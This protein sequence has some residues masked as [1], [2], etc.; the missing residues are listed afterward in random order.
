MVISDEYLI[1]RLN[2]L[3][4]KA[5]MNS[6]YLFTDFLNETELALYHEIENKLSPAGSSVYGGYSGAER[7]MVRFGS[8]EAFGYEEDFPIKCVYVQPLIVKFADELTHR[9]F[10]GALMN[11]GIERNVIGDLLIEGSS[12]YIFCE[13]KIADFIIENLDQVKH[14][15]MKCA[16]TDDI[17]DDIGHKTVEDEMQVASARIDAF[18]SK[19]CNMSRSDSIEMFRSQK[20]FVNGRTCENNAY[21]LKDGDVISARGFGKFRYV[22]TGGTTRKGKSVIIF[23]RYI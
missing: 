19:A 2:E 16:I 3:S 13:E 17:P 14:T 20:V 9:D 18:I 10:L 11:L 8:Q 22:R 6:Q 12:C 21:M 15:H 5:Y 7:C 23:E 4:D 1:K